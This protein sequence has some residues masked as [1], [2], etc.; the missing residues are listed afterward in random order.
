MTYTA[1]EVRFHAEDFELSGSDQE[2]FQETSDAIEADAYA[3]Q[4]VAAEAEE[5]SYW[6]READRAE[7]RALL[8]EAATDLPPHWDMP[9]YWEYEPYWD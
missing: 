2:W 7:C 8:H 1:Y 4:F 5:D 9:P 6:Q 3:S